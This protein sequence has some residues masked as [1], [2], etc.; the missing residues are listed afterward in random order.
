MYLDK[1]Q[2]LVKNIFADLEV[3]FQEID[4][5]ETMYMAII[6][7]LNKKIDFLEN[8]LTE[9]ER[10]HIEINNIYEKKMMYI[11]HINNILLESLLNTHKQIEQMEKESLF[12]KITKSFTALCI[13]PFK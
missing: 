7:K 8:Q 1:F 10:K 5:D 2:K 9:T 3:L 6:H 13:T 11:V 4:H 12:S